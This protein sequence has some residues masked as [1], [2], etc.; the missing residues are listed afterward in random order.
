MFR[1]TEKANV[2]HSFRKATTSI[3]SQMMSKEE[4]PVRE[5]LLKDV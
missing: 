4:I 3:R 1:E 5:Q 2:T